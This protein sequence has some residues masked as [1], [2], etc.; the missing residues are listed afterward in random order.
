M[1]SASAQKLTRTDLMIAVG[2]ES[3]LCFVS[4]I[5]TQADLME[6][7]QNKNAQNMSHMNN[8]WGKNLTK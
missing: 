8:N 1:A 7:I 6:R 5:S 2:I 3:V 4:I